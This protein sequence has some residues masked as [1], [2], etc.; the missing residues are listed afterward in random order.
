MGKGTAYLYVEALAALFAGYVSWVIISRLTTADIVGTA[1]TI[2]SIATI[3]TAFVSLG[4][5]TGIQGFL[6]RTFSENR[7][8]E[9][10]ALVSISFV[11]T[12]LAIAGCSIFMLVTSDWL[13]EVY[14]I[15]FIFLCLVIL[16]MASNAL[17][18]LF[19]S[20]IISSLKTRSLPA[21][22]ITSALARLLLLGILLMLGSDLPG[23]VI[24]YTS[25][26]L[27]SAILMA[28]VLIRI[29]IH[30]P[31]DQKPGNVRS[32]VRQILAASFSY[33]IPTLASVVGSQLGT[34]IVFGEHGPEQ[35]GVYFI[36]FLV[37]TAI[38]SISA[39]I[40]VITFPLISTMNDGRKRFAWKIIRLSLI[41]GMP[42]SI[43]ILFYSRDLLQL[44]GDRYVEGTLSLQILL[45]SI[46]PYI[47]GNGIGYL[48]YSY[49][50]Y[51]QVLLLGIAANVPRTVLYFILVPLFGE[52][53]AALS[54]TVGS[55]VD[56]GAAIFLARVIGFRILWGQLG[57]LV[58][59][60]S[61]IAF[62]LSYAGINYILGI[63]A[64]ILVS[65][66]LFVKLRILVRDDV[67]LALKM[68]P[69]SISRPAERIANSIFDKL[70]IPK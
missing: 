1:S 39:T 70:K 7:L 49:K 10:R 25:L 68:L 21:I 20:I 62:L 36:A 22:I 31:H 64:T 41:V 38:I 50:N 45:L 29:L 33:W 55:A 69:S 3:F 4:L 34:I 26:P 17:S 13:Y 35:A 9:T 30:R 37:Y 51:R 63:S 58:L 56:F 18:I 19:R 66:L 28:I 53:G 2:I 59:I 47:V 46:L 15:D 12:S 27:I 48:P 43:A 14:S 60:P 52:F 65:L 6:G 40:L 32:P 61:A 16:L 8:A 57:I 42:L 11:I 67:Q 54:F 44:M 23:I 5:P 24:A